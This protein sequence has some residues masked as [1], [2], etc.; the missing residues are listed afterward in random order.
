MIGSTE[1]IINLLDYSNDVLKL[2]FPGLEKNERIVNLNHII[3]TARYPHLKK[4]LR[5]YSDEETSDETSKT[6]EKVNSKEKEV[7]DPD[8]LELPP[9]IISEVLIIKVFHYK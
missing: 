4:E 8:N 1:D 5:I 9:V 7:I 6:K 3:L 2:L